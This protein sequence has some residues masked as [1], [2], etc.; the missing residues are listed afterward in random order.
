LIFI[1]CCNILIVGVPDKAEITP[2]EPDPG[3]AG[4]GSG[5]TKTI[6]R[7]ISYVRAKG[8]GSFYLLTSM[9]SDGHNEA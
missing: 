7:A 6:I 3:N 4:V 9:P 2:F 8:Y 1:R 5:D